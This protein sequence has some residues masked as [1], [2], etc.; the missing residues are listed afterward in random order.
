MILSSKYGLSI[1]PRDLAFHSTSERQ[2][3]VIF[4]TYIAPSLSD[5]IFVKKYLQNIVCLL[6]KLSCAV[7]HCIKVT[8]KSLQVQQ[9][10][11]LTYF[12]HASRCSHQ[13]M[14]R[15]NRLFTVMS[16]TTNLRYGVINISVF[17]TCNFSY[18]QTLV[19][20]C[21]SLNKIQNLR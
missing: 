7:G 3:T 17:T 13:V 14:S 15:I 18:F 10:N 20:Y 16:I 6:L 5:K 12:N 9:C 1:L 2:I 19:H 11:R 8:F 21:N 4:C